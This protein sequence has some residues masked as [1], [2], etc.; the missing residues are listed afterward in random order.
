[1]SEHLHESSLRAVFARG[2]RMFLPPPSLSL[3]EWADRY[4]YIPRETGAHPGKY[5]TDFAEYQRGIQDA[6]TD[7]NT[8]TVVMMMAAQTGKTQIQLNAIGYFSHWEPSA[9]LCMQASEREAEKFSKMRIAKMIRET[10]VLRPLYPS[11]RSRDSGNTLLTKEFPGGILV[12]AGAN[13]PAG[14]ASMPIRVLIPDEVDRYQ[15]SA[16]TEGDPVDLADK[17]TTTFWNRKKVL[18]STPGIKN[19]SRIER[20]WSASDQRSY[21]VPCPHCGEFQT[22]AWPR[23]K[24]RLSEGDE[25]R[26]QDWFYVCL[27]GCEIREDRKQQMVRRGEWRSARP[28]HDGKT[29][30]FALNALY[31]PTLDWEKLIQEWRESEGS[32]ERRKVFINTRLA[33]TWEIRGTGAYAHDI[34]GRA[35]PCADPLPPGVLWIT[36]GVDTQD[37]R[38]ECSWIGWGMS[39]ERWVLRHEVFF[40]DLGLPESYPESPWARLRDA[41]LQEW[42]HA[43][44]VTMRVGAVL[45]DSGGHFTERV[46]EFTRTHQ[47]RGWFPC[48]GRSGIG[49]PLLSAGS[50]VGPHKTLLYIVG[51]DTAKEDVFTS[52]RVA[53]PGGGYCHFDSSLPEE[54]YHQVTAEKLVERKVGFETRMEWVKTSPRNEALDCFVYARAAVNIR[55]PRF[56]AIQASLQR[57]ARQIA[58]AREQ[59]QPPLFAALPEPEVPASASGSPEPSPASPKTSPRQRVI[60]TLRRMR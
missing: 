56:H 26:L 17:R 1:M 33:E 49:R 38:L 44:G 20:A 27:N 25:R 15:E 8:E 31:S 35:E 50:R 34:Q 46:Y 42:P 43:V 24:Y 28:S 30:G 7:P 19:L 60:D 55:R 10:P 3:S 11:P 9:V 4:A 37:N 5:H 59:Q 16:G 23:L 22:L 53:K 39:D 40:G 36:C 54:Y 6:I 13:A 47:T 21:Y 29:A 41:L 58:E 18:A 52:F 2:A 14:L 32:L 57:A 51:V 12:I 45:I 48:I